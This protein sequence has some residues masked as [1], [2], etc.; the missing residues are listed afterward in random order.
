MGAQNTSNQNKAY[1]NIVSGKFAFR[2]KETTPNAVSRTNKNNVVVWEL[3]YD[4]LANMTISKIEKVESNDYGP[5]W[6]VTLKEV[7]ET[8]V[9]NLPYSGRTTNGLF[10]RLPNI[11]FGVPVTLKAFNIENKDK[12][13]TF[14]AYLTVEQAGAKVP[15]AFT[16]ETPN[17][18]PDMEQIMV[19]GKLTWDD[20]KQMVFMEKLLTEVIIP[21]IE[22]LNDVSP[23]PETSDPAFEGSEQDEDDLPF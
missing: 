8:Y 6:E 16:K 14:R 13:G 20:S 2:A 23:K 9:L 1:V 5:N 10:H 17:G 22:K 7:G 18:L 21:K 15:P 19:K 4:T 3:L 12:P 11:N